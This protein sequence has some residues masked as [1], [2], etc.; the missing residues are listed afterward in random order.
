MK[1]SRKDFSLFPTQHGYLFLGILLAM[2]LGSINYNNNAGFILVFFLGSMALISLVHSYKNLV[3]TRIS[4]G[5]ADP[6]FSGE[7]AFFP[8]AMNS[9]KGQGQSISL[10]FE[11]SEPILFSAGFKTGLR[12][13]S[14]TRK[15]GIHKPGKVILESVYPLGLFCLRAIIPEPPGGLV[16][17]A[18]ESGSY[19]TGQ[20][21]FLWEGDE[22]SRLQ[23]PDDFQGL[24][25]YL[26]G[27]PVGHISWKTLSKGKGLFIK[28]FTAETGGELLFD[29]GFIRG[30]HLEKK[31]SILCRALLDANTSQLTYGLKLGEHLYLTPDTGKGHLHNCLKALALYAPPQGGTP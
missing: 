31:L 11:S 25:P 23:G 4:L 20:A 16:Y 19:R 18:P 26:P 3:E 27:S 14:Q 21:G 13:P 15:R 6:V 28:N 29:L 22:E 24:A 17:P 2:L 10:C 8:V 1:L 12:L 30:N 5:D 9:P 7:T